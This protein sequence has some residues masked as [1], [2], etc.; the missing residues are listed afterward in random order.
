M[1]K[2]RLAADMTAPVVSLTVPV[3]LPPAAP[4][5]GMSAKNTR[6]ITRT[7]RF[8]RQAERI[9]LAVVGMKELSLNKWASKNSGNE[10]Q[11]L[12]DA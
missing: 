7:T 9:G 4:H 11:K 8:A 1:T 3:M 2:V 5:M 10:A 6:P 12:K